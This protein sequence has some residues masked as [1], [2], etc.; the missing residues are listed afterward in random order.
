MRKGQRG[1]SATV[2]LFATIIISPEVC[3]CVSG[4]EWE[5]RGG[6]ALMVGLVGSL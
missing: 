3:V 2:F 6:F 5:C 1:E 4:V